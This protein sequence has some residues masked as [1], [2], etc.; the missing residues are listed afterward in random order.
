MH[1]HLVAV[2]VSSLLCGQNFQKSF[3]EM[4]R[5]LLVVFA[6]VIELPTAQKTVGTM[7]KS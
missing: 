2:V 4:M 5:Y 7:R 3:L 6:L 1:N